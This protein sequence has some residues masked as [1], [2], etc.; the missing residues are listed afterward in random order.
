M[1]Y[2]LRLIV[3]MAVAVGLTL[4]AVHPTP[5]PSQAM[6]LAIQTDA[7]QPVLWDNLKQFNL[8]HFAIDEKVL[9]GKEMASCSCWGYTDMEAPDGVHIRLLSVDDYPVTMPVAERA[10]FQREVLQHE[11]LHIV[12]TRLHVPAE[13]QDAIIE[14]MTASGIRVPMVQH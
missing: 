9:S 12:L 14:G 13:A 6:A 4:I 8:T 5:A 11:V 2:L 7:L 1:K 3:A 10:K